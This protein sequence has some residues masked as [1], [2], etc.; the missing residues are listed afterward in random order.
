MVNVLLLTKPN[1]STT[2]NPTPLVTTKT[3][4]FEVFPL[5]SLKLKILFELAIKILK[6]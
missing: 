1:F 4:L 3:C 6:W 2:F 5:I